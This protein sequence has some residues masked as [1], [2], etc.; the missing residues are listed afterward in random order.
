LT[1][2]GVKIARHSVWGIGEM[3]V[4]RGISLG[5]GDAS[6]VASTHDAL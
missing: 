5:M 2:F 1:L 3:L 6:I 4:F